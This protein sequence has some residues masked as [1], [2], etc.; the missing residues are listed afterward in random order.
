MP[1]NATTYPWV[2][3]YPQGVAPAFD[4][5]PRPVYEMLED[6]VAKFAQRPG[7]DF[8][9]KKWTWGEIGKMVD[10]AAKGLQA[11]GVGKGCHVGLFL[12]NCLY[13]VVF[14]YAI[15]KAGGTVVNYNP[16]YSDKEVLNQVQDSETDIMVTC[17]LAALYEVETK[18]LNRAVRRNIDRFPDDFM[19]QLTL[20]EYEILRC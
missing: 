1:V 6:T 18:S 15:L 3:S 10:Q 7:F 8:L 5:K 16:L 9:D 2:A 13:F 4:F 19:F 11:H 17:D 14:Y 20:V 12:P